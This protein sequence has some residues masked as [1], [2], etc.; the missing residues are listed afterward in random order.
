[1]PGEEARA[2]WEVAAVLTK[3]CLFHPPCKFCPL[4][5]GQAPEMFVESRALP[6]NG[7]YVPVHTYLC[8]CGYVHLCTNACISQRVFSSVPLY[9]GTCVQ[10]SRCEH[11]HTCAMCEVASGASSLG[12]S[13]VTV[14]VDFVCHFPVAIIPCFGALP[15]CPVLCLTVSYCKHKEA[16]LPF[17]IYEIVVMSVV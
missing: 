7:L 5:H 12:K 15:V 13:L 14:P 2:S 6:Q 1:M 9:L 17:S 8:A 3:A 10:E 4:N 16:N 11:V